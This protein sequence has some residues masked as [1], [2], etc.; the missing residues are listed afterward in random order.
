VFG[1]YI[2]ESKTGRIDEA[3]HH[4]LIEKKISLATAESCTG[5]AL[6]AR[7]VQ[8]AGASQYFQGSIIAYS[9]EVKQD[10]LSV[11]SNLLASYG[12]VSEEVAYAMA[13]QVSKKMHAMCGIAVSG[14][15]GPTGGSP[16]KPVGTVCAAIAFRNRP[17]FSWTMRFTG[18]REVILEKAIQHIFSELLFFEKTSKIWV[19][20][21]ISRFGEIFFLPFFSH[22]N[23][24]S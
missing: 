10:V 23:D 24:F 16:E 19:S 11:D 3:L 2:F 5:G 4:Y 20:D 13:E 1:D 8:Q 18:N 6:A 9:N 14:I 22:K 17:T 15:L 7:L 21:L 12:A